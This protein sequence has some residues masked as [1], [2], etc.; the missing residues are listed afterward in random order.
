MQHV[1]SKH[2]YNNTA[3]SLNTFKAGLSNLKKKGMLLEGLFR[4]WFPI[5]DYEQFN[6]RVI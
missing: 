1:F 3:P 5:S 2:I 4:D 6:V